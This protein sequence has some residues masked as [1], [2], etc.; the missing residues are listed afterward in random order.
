MMPVRKYR[1]ISEMEDNTWHEPGSP[2]HFRAMRNTWA[3]AQRTLGYRFPPGVYK[4]RSIEEAQRQREIW[5]QSCFE[6]YQARKRAGSST[7]GGGT[8]NDAS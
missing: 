8:A 2:E 1:D 6:A 7:P 3:F 4:H 5:E